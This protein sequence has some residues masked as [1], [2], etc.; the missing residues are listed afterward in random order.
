MIKRKEKELLE[1]KFLSPLATKSKNS[2]GRLKKETEDPFRTA[3]QRDRDRIIHSKAFRR[4]MDKTQVFIN[5]YDDHLRRRLTHTIEVSQISRTIASLLG[6]NED[7]TEA[8]ALGH[9]LGHTPFG[10]LGESILREVHSKSFSHN[11]QSL[12]VVDCLEINEKR[13]GLNL[14]KEVRDGILNH[15]GD[16]M[17]FTLE[18]Q[19]VKIAD[20][21]AYVNHDIDDALRAKIL[22]KDDI[23]KEVVKSLGKTKS[24]RITTLVEDLAKNS[25]G[26]KLISL[27]KEKQKNLLLLRAFLTKNV[28]L[29]KDIRKKNEEEKIKKLIT[30]LYKFY[31]ENKSEIPSEYQNLIKKDGIREVAKDS[32]ASMTDKYAVKKYEDFFVP[33]EF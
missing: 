13:T 33:K 21:I 16:K 27:S 8:I 23:P 24:E 26:K 14:T 19:I 30:F 9:D 12:R 22:K 3:F 28:Y 5:P 32:V 4:L 10:H 31:I 18:G 20:R 7:L 2:K 17:P 25:D 11:K 1:E 15:T 29:G 6:L